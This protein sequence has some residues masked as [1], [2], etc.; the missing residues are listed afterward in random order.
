MSALATP[1]PARVFGPGIGSDGKQATCRWQ[2]GGLL[3][4]EAGGPDLIAQGEAQVSPA[5]FTAQQAWLTVKG[6][7]AEFSVFVEN[8]AA[9]LAMLADAPAH[10]R[11]QAEALQRK[12]RANGRLIR[13]VVVGAGFLLV[14]PVLL[15]LVFLLNIGNLSGWLAAQVP[16]HYETQIGELVL[17]RSRAE[18]TLIEKGPAYEAVRAIGARLTTGSRFQ[19]RWFVADNKQVNAFAAPGGVVVVNTGLIALASTP[20]ELA[21]VLAHE[22]AH[23]ERRHSLSQMI[24]NVGTVAALGMLL[25][26][27]SDTIAGSMATQLLSL[28]YSRNAELDA[29]S[30]G[31][32]RMIAA[33]IDPAS[34]AAF[35][36]KLSD[37]DKGSAAA[38]IL[39]SHPASKERARALREQLAGQPARQYEP[40]P[41]DWARVQAARQAGAGG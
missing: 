8:A 11:S 13:A 21:G 18:S 41:I 9:R 27:W 10:I 5:G 14:L 23:V 31:M 26:D 37:K 15:L 34:M 1:F 36:D 24:E 35:F 16:L 38:A 17:A 33:G 29:D 19:Y 39:S 3:I 32:Q 6:R 30:Y 4:L 25:G 28:K 7:E 12:E 22:V 20:E 40:L 2:A